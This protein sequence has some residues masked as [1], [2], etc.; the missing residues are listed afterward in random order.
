MPKY[1]VKVRYST[2]DPELT[3]EARPH[4]DETSN[5]RELEEV[6]KT[7]IE[8][9]RKHVPDAV[10]IRINEAGSLQGH[11]YGIRETSDDEMFIWMTKQDAGQLIRVFARW[12]NT[13]RPTLWFGRAIDQTV[14][15]LNQLSRNVSDK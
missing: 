15:R 1:F 12:L 11:Y 4:W 3:W 9:L 2:D 5:I 7:C 13:L 14:L 8:Y 10:E 6:A